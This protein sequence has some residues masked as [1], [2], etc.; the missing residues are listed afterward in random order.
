MHSRARVKINVR[1]RSIFICGAEISTGPW[2]PRISEKC[3][4]ISSPTLSWRLQKRPQAFLRHW[5]I[6]FGY[7]F[8][9]KNIFSNKIKAIFCFSCSLPTLFKKIRVA[10]NKKSCFPWFRCSQWSPA[11]S[12][13]CFFFFFFCSRHEKPFTIEEKAF[14]HLWAPVMQVL[15]V[16]RKCFLFALSFALSLFSH[17]LKL[18]HFSQTS[19]IS[20]AK[21][22]TNSRE[23]LWTAFKT[24]RNE[25][26]ANKWATATHR[27]FKIFICGLPNTPTE[28]KIQQIS[29]LKRFW[30]LC[31]FYLWVLLFSSCLKKFLHFGGEGERE[32]KLT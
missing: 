13:A 22:A 24:F 11:P 30:S 14:F 9:E 26:L 23:S 3:A 29:V 19:E 6:F 27:K 12:I 31:A 28:W 21:T 25:T 16:R 7:F 1:V 10:P 5:Y 20:E 2:Y 32:G 8:Y 17:N 4:Q 18:T 15:K